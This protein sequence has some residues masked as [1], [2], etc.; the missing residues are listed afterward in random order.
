[1]KAIFTEITRYNCW[2]LLKKAMTFLDELY[3][4][5]FIMVD[6]LGSELF[7]GDDLT[8]WWYTV[9]QTDCVLNLIQEECSSSVST[10]ALGDTTP[11]MRSY[12]EQQ[13]T[14]D[15]M[16]I[17]INPSETRSRPEV[18]RNLAHCTEYLVF[19]IRSPSRC[20]TEKRLAHLDLW[21]TR[22]TNF[23]LFNYLKNSPGHFCLIMTRSPG[24]LVVSC[25]EIYYQSAWG[26]VHCSVLL[27]IFQSTERRRPSASVRTILN[28]L[29]R[30][31][32]Y[33]IL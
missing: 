20:E 32:L 30:L 7:D 27:I 33:F 19:L 5:H 17:Q 25:F 8:Y 22:I 14:D 24:M 26:R 12:H 23:I 29:L 13:F 4:H 21:D 6:V 31:D 1:M 10:P 16:V 11:R 3:I 2:I 15:Q 9:W 18:S 28:L